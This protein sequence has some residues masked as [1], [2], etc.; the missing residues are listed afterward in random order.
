[1]HLIQRQDKILN[2]MK[3]NEAL[4]GVSVI[5]G[6]QLEE[7]NWQKFAIIFARYEIYEI[8]GYLGILSPVRADYR[9]LIPLV[10]DV[11]KTITETTRRGMMVKH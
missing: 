2:L 4:E 11:A 1:M 7:P 10:R 9:K 6:E 3:Q 8:P 5:M